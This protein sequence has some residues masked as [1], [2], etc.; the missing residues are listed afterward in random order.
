MIFSLY[1]RGLCRWISW[2]LHVWSLLQSCWLLSLHFQSFTTLQVM[3]KD[4]TRVGKRVGANGICLQACL[5]R[6]IQNKPKKP[7]ST[8]NQTWAWKQGISLSVL[9]TNKQKWDF[10]NSKSGKNVLQGL[11]NGSTPKLFVSVFLLWPL[12]L[13]SF[14]TEK[15]WCDMCQLESSTSPLGSAEPSTS[16]LCRHKWHLCC[17]II[18]FFFTSVSPVW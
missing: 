5:N 7:N 8:L 15:G 12:G 6:L 4:F 14:K 3:Q 10:S 9:R 13:T 16:T 11:S 17:L 18:F 2:S 1:L